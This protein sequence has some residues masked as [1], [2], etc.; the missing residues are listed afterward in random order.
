MAPKLS[1]WYRR[2]RNA[3]FAWVDGRQ[4]RLAS[5]KDN[6]RA[7][8]ISLGRLLSCDAPPEPPAPPRLASATSIVAAYLSDLEGRAARGEIRLTTVA[9]ARRRLAGAEALDPIGADSVGRWLDGRKLGPASR[10]DCFAAL[11]SALRHAVVR[12]TIDRNPLEGVRTPRRRAERRPGLTD[13][14]ARHAMSRATPAAFREFLLILY[15]TG[16]RPSEVARMTARDFN[17]RRAI[18]TLERHKSERVGRPRVIRLGWPAFLRV[19]M[20]AALRPSGPLFPS[21]TGRAWTRHG[22]N[23]AL[24]RLRRE[25]GQGPRLTLYAFRHLFA[26]ELLRRGAGIAATAALLG[27][28]S[29][30]VL[31]YYSHL[32]EDGGALREVLDTPR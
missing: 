5:G 20:A 28:S 25:I 19:S 12:G 11:R 9:D 31:E 18:V 32:D 7:A 23:S 27:H 6:Y 15:L 17:P 2:D 4:V 10:A 21:S 14:E 8:L 16:A 22:L 30:R 13:E 29:T 26:T 24:R 3:W 1:P